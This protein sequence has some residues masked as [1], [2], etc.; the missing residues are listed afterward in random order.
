ME[1]VKNALIGFLI[2][3]VIGIV[4]IYIFKFVWDITVFEDGSFTGC[5]PFAICNLP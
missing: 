4:L 3:I 1:D 2:G 5:L